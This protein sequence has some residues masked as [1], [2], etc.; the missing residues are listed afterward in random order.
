MVWYLSYLFALEISN[1]LRTCPFFI[2]FRPV[3]STRYPDISWRPRGRNEEI[4]VLGQVLGGEID[5][6]EIRKKSV[7]TFG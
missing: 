6:I 4:A 2:L 1:R 7:S 5:V 3:K